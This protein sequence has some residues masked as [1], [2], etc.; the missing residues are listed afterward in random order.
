MFQALEELGLTESE[1]K[2]YIALL[3]KGP[4]LAGIITK[5]TGIHRRTIYDILYRLRS[6]GLI[7]NIIIN[8][9]RYFEAVDPDRLL[10]IL[11]EKEENIKKHLPELKVLYKT[12]KEKKEVVFFRGKPAMKSVFDDQLKEGK[13]ILMI[14][15]CIDVNEIIKFYFPRYDE[16]RKKK[17]ISMKII[18]DKEDKKNG[19]GKKIPLSKIKYIE[20][21]NNSTMSSY[22][23]GNNVSLILW[24][25]DPIATL[26]R[27]KEFADGF[28]DRF[29]ILWG[30]AE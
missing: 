4:S 5:E 10:D 24:S 27:Q 30:I 25:E 14:G 16:E 13:E 12:T 17:K 11:R 21:I 28:R 15:K 22:V 8:N 29:N 2:V 1:A 3:R 20:G 6:K 7:S 18:F 26:I 23:Y 19:S 9:N